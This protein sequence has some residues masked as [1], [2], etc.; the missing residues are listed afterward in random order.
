[1]ALYLKTT[2]NYKKYMR[3]SFFD[4]I[5]VADLACGI[6]FEVNFMIFITI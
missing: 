5:K 1:M 6:G 2:L 3:F 4:A